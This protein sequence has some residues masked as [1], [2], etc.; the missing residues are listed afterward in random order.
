MYQGNNGSG[1]SPITF[2]IMQD[3]T[4]QYIMP[5]EQLT[6]NSSSIPNSF[7][8]DGKVDNVTNVVDLKS[9][10]NDVI[11]AVTKDGKEIKIWNE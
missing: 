7:K 3:G 1:V 9:N 4:V 6:N 8:I 11:I 2:F 5:L 10:S